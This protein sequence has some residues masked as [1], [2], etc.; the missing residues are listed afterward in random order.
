VLVVSTSLSEGGSERFASWLITHLDRSG[1][2]PHLCLMRDR[3]TYNLPDDV[4]LEVLHRERLWHHGRAVWRL[5]G[6]LERIRPQAV[7]G[8][9]AFCGRLIGAASRLSR[10]KP[11]WVVRFAADPRPDDGPLVRMLTRLTCASAARFV[12]NSRGLVAGLERFYP[13]VAGRI[14][15]IHNP[16]DFEA[17]DRLAG[18]EAD[19]QPDS[20]VPVVISVGRLNR[21]KRLDILVDAFDHVRRRMPAELWIAGEGPQRKSLESR[22]DKRGLAGCVR[23]L[24]FRDNPYALMRR[25]DLFVLSSD[26]EGLPNALIEAQGLGLP[27]VSTR[28]PYGPDEIIEDGR[29]GALVPVGDEGA[30]AEE[31][32]RLLFDADKRAEMGKG[33]RERAR[34]LFGAKKLIGQWEDL[35][36]SVAEG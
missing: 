5:R 36:R 21:Q 33:A 2:E 9:L 28:C 3:I 29:T 8:T 22:I 6:L 24:G 26:Y 23:L 31:I 19:R 32:L 35:L 13:F 20:G 27:A 14:T 7:V 4:P 1:F 18:E 34:R 12:G 30:L 10:F 11:P 17:I 16:T 25:A 15:S